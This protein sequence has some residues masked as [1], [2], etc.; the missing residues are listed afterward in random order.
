MTEEDAVYRGFRCALIILVMILFLTLL[1]PAVAPA[2][3]HD[4]GK[5]GAAGEFYA[6]WQMPNGGNPRISSCCNKNDCYATTIKQVAGVWVGRQREPGR[7]IVIPDGKLEENLPDERKTPDGQSH[8]CANP[9]GVL[10]CA[11]RGDGM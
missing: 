4:H 10:Y 2:E 7:W 3:E 1:A 8:M 5:L 6:K 11:V 9:N